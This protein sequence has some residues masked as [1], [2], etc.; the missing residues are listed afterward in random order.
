M[1]PINLVISAD[2]EIRA[3][4]LAC[5]QLSDQTEDHYAVICGMLVGHV[6]EQTPEATTKLIND[7]VFH[8]TSI[9]VVHPHDIL[10]CCL[11]LYGKLALQ[12]IHSHILQGIQTIYLV[13]TYP[14]LVVGVV[15]YYAGGNNNR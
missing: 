5:S 10:D 12:T 15:T 13:Q 2:D 11:R 4:R 1:Q 6:M 14:H 8:L 7:L 3:L 9:D